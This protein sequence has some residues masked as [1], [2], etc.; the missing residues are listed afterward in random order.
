MEAKNKSVQK[1][2]TEARIIDILGCQNCVALEECLT[3]EP[4]NFCT[5][6]RDWL[7]GILAL[8][9]KWAKEA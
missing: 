6:K 1:L 7:K 8:F 4:M 9:E 2:S 5:D 3:D